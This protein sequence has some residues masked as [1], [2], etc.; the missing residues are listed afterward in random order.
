MRSWPALSESGAVCGIRA[1]QR[2]RCESPDFAP[3][4]AQIASAVRGLH[5]RRLRNLSRIAG[6]A[7]HCATYGYRRF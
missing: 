5:L 1:E 7:K 4:S 2:A 3:I 6:C